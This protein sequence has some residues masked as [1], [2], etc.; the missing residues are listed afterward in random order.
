MTRAVRTPAAARTAPAAQDTVVGETLAGDT[1]TAEV[2]PPGA[3]PS[4]AEFP[5]PQRPTTVWE[6]LRWWR[7]TARTDL[8]ETR[9]LRIRDQ[10]RTVAMA[11]LLITRRAGGLLFYDPPRLAGSEGAMAEPDLLDEPERERWRTLTARTD[12]ARDEQY[13]SLALATFGNHPGVV[14]DPARTAAQRA[15]VWAALPRLVARAAE[16]LGCRSSALLYAGDA[17]RDAADTSA[18]AH[19]H[20]RVLLGAEGVLHLTASSNEEY[21]AGLSSRRRTRLRRE[22]R[23]YQK[24]GFRTVVREGPGALDD[25]VIALQVAHRAKYGL[26]G[27]EAR[28]RRDFEATAQEMGE[29]CLVLGAERDGRLHGFLLH[30]RTPDALYA[31][32]AGFAPDADG[33]YLA[34]TYHETAGWAAEHG[35]RRV[36]YGLASYEAK[37]ARGCDLEPRWGWFAF[38]GSGRD[39]YEELLRLQ[40]LTIE[41]RLELVGAPTA[42]PAPSGERA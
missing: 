30:L 9:F 1:L 17:Q 22:V 23:E 3:F 11:P 32:T 29:D 42:P 19:G 8:H 28:V 33:C 38:G 25:E 10:G 14:H 2:L 27:G 34:L 21:V 13:P 26:P 39:A 24:A 31:R 35:I 40:S 37:R 18:T 20:Q 12:Q 6:D 7:F 16:E 5:G 41:R 15:A 4:A 36:H